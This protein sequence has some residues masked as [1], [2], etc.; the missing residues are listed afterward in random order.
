MGG[1][2]GYSLQNFSPALYSSSGASFHLPQRC[3]EKKGERYA[4]GSA[5]GGRTETSGAAAHCGG[6]EELLDA[7]E[8]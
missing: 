1:L 4:Y 3:Y 2:G 8:S 6:D 7:P 5:Q